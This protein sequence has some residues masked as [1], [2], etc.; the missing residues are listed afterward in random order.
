MKKKMFDE[1]TKNYHKNPCEMCG[2]Y[3]LCKEE[4]NEEENIWRIVTK[5]EDTD[6]ESQPLMCR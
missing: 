6:K 5:D 2:S 4:K 1:R 3:F